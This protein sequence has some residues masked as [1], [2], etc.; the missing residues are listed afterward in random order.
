VALP[1]LVQR[2]G[3]QKLDDMPEYAG[4]IGDVDM[5]LWCGAYSIQS[6]ETVKTDGD[7][8]VPFFKSNRG[9][10]LLSGTPSSMERWLAKSIS[11]I[12]SSTSSRGPPGR[13]LRSESTSHGSTSSRS[14]FPL[15]INRFQVHS[16][17]VHY[18]D[19]HSQPKV[20]LKIDQIEMLGTN[21]TNS[22]KL[23][24]SP[25]TDIKISGRAFASAPLGHEYPAPFNQPRNLRLGG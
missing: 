3:N 25:G 21:L 7:V 2:Y 12:L 18:R 17:T 20:D 14:S 13:Q 23:S 11:L 22:R 4:R 6:I 15:N 8:P 1:H 9:R 16:G 19:F 5:H 10:F 24:E